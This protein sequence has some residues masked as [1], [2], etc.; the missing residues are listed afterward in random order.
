MERLSQAVRNDDRP[1]QVISVATDGE[2][3]G[4]HK[5]GTEKCLPY[6][7]STEFPQRHWTVTNL[8][9]Y[10]SIS[11][12]VWSVELKPVTAWSCFHGVERWQND[13]GCGGAGG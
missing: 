10:L 13:C 8:A 1:T 4:H 3:F 12:P 2:T 5:G 11:P 9:N 6:A 7:F